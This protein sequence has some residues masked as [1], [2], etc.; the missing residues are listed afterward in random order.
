MSLFA[1]IQASFKD[2]PK[3][4]TEL[5]KANLEQPLGRIASIATELRESEQ[6]SPITSR[7]AL[8][9][10]LR[11]I[12]RSMRA[13]MSETS[14]LLAVWED[15]I[16]AIRKSSGPRENAAL[17]L[18]AS[19]VDLQGRSWEVVSR[20][21]WR[22]IGDDSEAIVEAKA[23]LEGRPLP[24]PDG[25][26]RRA[27]LNAASRLA[28]AKRLLVLEPPVAPR[29]VW[30]AYFEASIDHGHFSLGDHIDVFDGRLLLASLRAGPSAGFW[31]N[32]PEE[33]RAN[34]NACLLSWE[35]KGTRPF[36][37]VRL[38]LG[39]RAA[40]HVERDAAMVRDLLPRLASFYNSG[41][42]SWQP[43]DSFVVFTD[44]QLDWH[45]AVLEYPEEI[46]GMN[47]E[48]A[49]DRTAE[50]LTTLEP[51]V[52]PHLLVRDERVQKALDLMEWLVEARGTW[53]PARML[54]FDRI[55]ERVAGWAD[56]SDPN[57]F[58]R[59]YLMAPWALDQFTTR[60]AEY[61]I[62]AVNS[63]DRTTIGA[64]P[65]PAQRAAREKADSMGLVEHAPG[66]R[67][68][69]NIPLAL[70]Q[71]EWLC[72]VQPRG[73]DGANA[74]AELVR[75]AGTPAA[76][77]RSLRGLATEFERLLS[78]ARRTRNAIAHGGPIPPATLRTVSPFY[79]QLANDSLNQSLHAFT[80]GVNLTAHLE[81]RGEQHAKVLEDLQA[82][83]S[84]NVAL[85]FNGV[86]RQESETS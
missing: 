26:P 28:L 82:E 20:S 23:E 5:T 25:P 31:P 24:E 54:L 1:D 21:L 71:L 43:S 74:A 69:A 63:I 49:R 4:V 80:T 2:L 57:H 59:Q 50:I 12:E 72:S 65:D 8:R 6:S 38:Q 55:L 3:T 48:L 56:D 22:V 14:V 58:A 33:V 19:C 66:M 15:L 35:A 44:G 34:R 18:L 11:A 42:V 60:L 75:L 46:S 29:V 78:R 9:K 41:H 40:A 13:T 64:M 37:L 32:V 61:I 52:A 36:V 53:E 77:K 27:G 68:T 85:F 83:V 86:P 67:V 47:Y 7:D 76:A 84:P 10:E 51:I 70:K 17:A 81:R 79:H 62:K 16:R 45:T 73:S 30:I 39:E